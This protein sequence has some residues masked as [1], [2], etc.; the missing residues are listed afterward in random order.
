MTDTTATREAVQIYQLFIKATP[1]AIWDA[2]TKPEFTRRYFYGSIVETTGVPGTPFRYYAPDGETLW[3]DETVL[4]SDPPRR[5]VVGWRSLYNED[6]A[7]EP[8]SRITWDIDPQ[9]GGFSL[10]TVTHD[11]LEQSPITAES[12]SGLGWLM[13]LSGLKTLLE[14][15]SPLSD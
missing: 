4:A 12:V 2:I 6:A 8:A 5:L 7:G 14:T 1:E 3:N 9:D 10:L 13:V 11:Q 15:G